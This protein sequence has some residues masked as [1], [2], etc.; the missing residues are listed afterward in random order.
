LD[1]GD[2]PAYARSVTASA[3]QYVVSIHLGHLPTFETIALNAKLVDVANLRSAEGR[4]CFLVVSERGKTLIVASFRYDLAGGLG[5]AIAI[6]PERQRLFVGAG[7]ELLCYDLSEPRRL[8]SDKADTGLWKWE[9]VDD[10]VL[11]SAELELAAWDQSGE[12]L[13]SRFVEPPW[14]YTVKAG[15]V[16]LDVMGEISTFG[17]RVGPSRPS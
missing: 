1:S 14:S 4:P 13:W 9:I 11:M 3:G 15:Q 10:T 5:P 17:L 12:K 2:L 7:E 8:W 16:T 6:I